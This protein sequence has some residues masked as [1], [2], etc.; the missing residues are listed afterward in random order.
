MSQPL[1][2][3]LRAAAEG[4]DEAFS[5]LEERYAPLI[6]SMSSRYASS[7]ARWDAAAVGEQDLEQEARL[8]L[9]NAVRSYDREQSEVS[10]GLYAKICIRNS[11]VSALRR[12]RAASRRK[13]TARP[14]PS[15][16]EDPL[17]QYAASPDADPGLTDRIQSILS[18]YERRIFAQHIHGRS[19]KS[20]AASV[21]RPERSV[22][23]ALYRIRVKI[24]GLLGSER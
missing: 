11:F 23:N 9:L 13:R 12:L 18:P 24:K 19:V 6:R 1:H 22:S 15:A 21:G 7:F 3:L 5:R 16:G 8:A 2:D 20:I 10:F 14:A 4:D 17:L